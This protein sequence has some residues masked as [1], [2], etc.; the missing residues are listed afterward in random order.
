MSDPSISLHNDKDVTFQDG[1]PQRSAPTTAPSSTTPTLTSTPT[2]TFKET[3]IFI[4]FIKTTTS[5]FS[6]SNSA[7][8]SATPYK[9]SE[10]K[11]I[12]EVQ[13]IM[14]SLL[15]LW[16]K[17]QVNVNHLHLLQKQTHQTP[18]VKTTASPKSKRKQK[19]YA[20]SEC[21]DV[22]DPFINDS[23]LNID[24]R[25]HFAQIKQQGFYVSSGEVSLIKDRT[26][27]KPQS[28][29]A[30]TRL[31]KKR[32]NYTV[33]E[34]KRKIVDLRDFH[35]ELQLAIEDLKTAISKEPWDVKGKFPPS[36][37]PILADVALKAV[38]LGEYDEDFFN[39]IP[40]LFPY[41]CFTMTILTDR[42]DELAARGAYERRVFESAGGAGEECCCLGTPARKRPRTQPGQPPT[43]MHISYDRVYKFVVIDRIG[44]KSNAYFDIPCNSEA[45]STPFLN[46]STS[47]L[48]PSSDSATLSNTLANP[49]GR[50]LA[51]LR[52]GRVGGP[53][54]SG[55]DCAA[56]MDEAFG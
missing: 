53:R 25:T 37:K 30:K 20:T 49:R 29:K 39:L 7:P 13:M 34:K 6:L 2:I 3:E 14:K 32:K 8:S 38:N 5:S 11:S 15:L 33:L 42:R 52:R 45:Y 21:Y 10:Y 50:R 56:C 19:K 28:K 54:R 51:F 46:V 40:M 48:S 44:A 26:P 22:N 41:N 36:I 4:F 55:L 31:N 9:L 43:R 23:E 18:N 27:E 1:M 35:P 12:W 17:Q 16:Q 24:N 47:A